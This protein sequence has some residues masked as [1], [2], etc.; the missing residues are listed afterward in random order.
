MALGPFISYV[1]PGVYTRTL[2]EA[3]VAN[4]VAGLRIPVVIGVGQEELT[5]SDV[6]LVRGSSATVDQ[7]IN[8]E[9]VSLAW[10]VDSTNPQNLLLG[11][12]DGTRT[13]FQVRNRPIVDG[14]GFGRVTNDIRTITVTVNGIPVS[15]GSVNGQ[16]G[17]VTLQV[18]TQPTDLVR[19]TYFFHRGDTAF[20]EIGR[21]H[22]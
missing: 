10:V 21:A 13:T 22:V 11:T 20:M 6:E 5:Q 7:Q 16:K 8:N 1:P 4:I 15:V 18:P 12:Q 17:L 3:N 14:Q 9:D 2:T 19:C